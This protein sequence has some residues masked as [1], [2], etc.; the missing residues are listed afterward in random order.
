LIL[1]LKYKNILDSNDLAKFLLSNE[2]QLRKLLHNKRAD[3]YYGGFKLKFSMIDGKDIAAFNNR[4]NIVVKDHGS[5]K[6]IP[7]KRESMNCKTMKTKE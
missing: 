6:V 7:K 2:F 1:K 5:I 3:S 4:Y